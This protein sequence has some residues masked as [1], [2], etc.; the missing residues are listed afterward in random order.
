[1]TSNMFARLRRSAWAAAP[2]SSFTSGGTRSVS[3]AV[4]VCV[5]AKASYLSDSACAVELLRLALS[6]ATG[7]SCNAPTCEVF[8]TRSGKLGTNIRQTP[9][10][11][12]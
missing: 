9:R 7:T 8:T 10:A 11:P 5:R 12:A 3:V 6:I 2:S 4:L 1:M